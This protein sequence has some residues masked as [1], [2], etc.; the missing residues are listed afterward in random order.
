METTNDNVDRQA[1][2]VRLVPNFGDDLSAQQGLQSAADSISGTAGTTRRPCR[3]VN[4][5]QSSDTVKTLEKEASVTSHAHIVY[6]SP[7]L[8]P[9]A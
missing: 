9:P 8:L 7:S 2:K 1:C 3:Y 4:G 5:N 6:T